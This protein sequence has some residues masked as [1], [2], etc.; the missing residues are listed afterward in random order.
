MKSSTL[1][2]GR[3]SRN[4]DRDAFVLLHG[5]LNVQGTVIQ[6]PISLAVKSERA[7][8]GLADAC[9]GEN[10]AGEVSLQILLQADVVALFIPRLW[11]HL[12][13]SYCL[14]ENVA[15][16]E[17]GQTARV[18]TRWHT[19][20]EGCRNPKAA[21]NRRRACQDQRHHHGRRWRWVNYRE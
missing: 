6:M 13:R 5:R 2:T 9:Q 12:A 14:D 16:I 15:N 11:E 21:Q 17:V 10:D 20:R 3:A 19:W 4:A 18:V 8:T 1:E 7:D